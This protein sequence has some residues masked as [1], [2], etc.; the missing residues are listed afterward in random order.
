EVLKDQAF[1]YFGKERGAGGL[2]TGVGGRVACLLSGGIDSPVAAWRVMRRG[3]RAQLIHFHAY[4]IVSSVSQEKVRELAR[5]L[6][7]APDRHVR[8][9]DSSRRRLLPAVHAA[10]AGDARAPRRARCGGVIAASR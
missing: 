5:W 7:R 9:L 3:C 2:P 1:Y 10:G 8:H 4:P 6:T